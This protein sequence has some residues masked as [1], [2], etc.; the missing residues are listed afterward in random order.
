M[1]KKRR[2]FTDSLEAEYTFLKEDQQVGKVLCSICKSQLSVEHG[3]CS[4]V[5]QHSRKENTQL[6]QKLKVAVKK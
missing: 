2:V 3:G 5:L 4:D 1:P 6:L